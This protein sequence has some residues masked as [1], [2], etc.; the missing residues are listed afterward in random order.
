MHFWCKKNHK[1]NIC[2]YSVYD[3]IILCRVASFYMHE[4]TFMHEITHSEYNLVNN[5]LLCLIL[6]QFVHNGS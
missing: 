4:Y 3:N 6:K 1:L 2:I 5:I